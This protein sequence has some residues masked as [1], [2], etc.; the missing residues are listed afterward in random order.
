MT[1]IE[2]REII[3]PVGNLEVMPGMEDLHHEVMI[4]FGR[5][6]ADLI[7]GQ[8]NEGKEIVVACFLNGAIIPIAQTIAQLRRDAYEGKITDDLYQ[9]ACNSIVLFER[10]RAKNAETNK[11]ET[12]ATLAHPDILHTVTTAI[13][14]DD[15]A[16]TLETTDDLHETFPNAEIIIAAAVKKHKTNGPLQQ[17]GFPAQFICEVGDK[18]LLSGCGMD[19][20]NK[21]EEELTQYQLAELSILQRCSNVGIYKNQDKGS[22]PDYKQQFNFFC[23]HSQLL[24]WVTQLH[25]YNRFNN[26]DVDADFL[27]ELIELELAKMKKDYT[28]QMKLGKQIVD[29]FSQLDYSDVVK[30]TQ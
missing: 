19:G 5:Q 3:H 22:D 29:N 18:W 23:K 6:T 4:P 14:V 20:S 27:N 12:V 11:K 8:I 1:Q 25:S 7:T 15:I 13:N 17:R 10:I 28:R 30:I 24:P 9:Q 2:A 26:S 16:E 21:F